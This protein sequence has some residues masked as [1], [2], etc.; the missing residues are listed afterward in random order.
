M[1]AMYP[2]NYV[3]IKLL[4]S[5]HIN[6][7]DFIEQTMTISSHLCITCMFLIKMPL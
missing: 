4:L 1:Q 5:I 7:F 6:K 2:Y 3:Y